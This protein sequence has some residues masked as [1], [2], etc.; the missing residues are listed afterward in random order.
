[1]SK[2]TTGYFTQSAR[3]KT[4]SIASG[5]TTVIFTAGANGSKI[6]AISTGSTTTVT[7]KLLVN[8]G[9]TDHEVYSNGSLAADT[10]L[11]ALTAFP[12]KAAG[13][14]Y[15]N[16]ESGWTIKFTGGGGGTALIMVYGEDY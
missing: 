15:F 4:T 3:T 13:S 5:S 7:G 16:L 14:K 11:L 8:D 6:L 10:D 9:S 2:N 1:M 12:Q